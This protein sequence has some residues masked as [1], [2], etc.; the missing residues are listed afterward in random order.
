ML[1]GLPHSI[2]GKGIENISLFRKVQIVN[3][4]RA[5]AYPVDQIG[6]VYIVM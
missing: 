2:R 1:W 6:N 4:G 3:V 5:S